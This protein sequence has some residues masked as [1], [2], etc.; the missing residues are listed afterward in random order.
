MLLWTD[1]TYPVAVDNGYGNKDCELQVLREWVDGQWAISYSLYWISPDGDDE[2]DL[3]IDEAE[4]RKI[5]WGE[6]SKDTDPWELT[7]TTP[8]QIETEVVELNICLCTTK[9]LAAY[10]CKCGQIDRERGRK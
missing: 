5:L 6:M 9:D 10:G 2:S 1:G 8:E 3:E 4:A 7:I